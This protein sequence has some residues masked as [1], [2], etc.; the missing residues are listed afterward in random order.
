MQRPAVLLI[1]LMAGTCLLITR[2][3]AEHAKMP[4]KTTI[5]FYGQNAQDDNGVGI[6]GVNL[7]AFKPT[8]LKWQGTPVYPVAV[9]EKDWPRYAY[10]VLRIRGNGVRTIYGVVLDAC[11][12]K[13]AVCTTNSRKFGFLVDV[14][15]A[16]YKAIGRSDGLVDGTFE[17]VGS[18]SA[19]DIPDALWS[20]SVRRGSNYLQCR[21]SNGKLAW[22][23]LK[24]RTTTCR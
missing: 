5:S 21:G 23:P 20:S 19:A 3:Y 18:I 9:A 17:E 10:K 22:V 13:D 8:S 2:Q 15:R 6:S 11:A 4:G 14:H 12:K 16:G 1:A 7:L 24:N